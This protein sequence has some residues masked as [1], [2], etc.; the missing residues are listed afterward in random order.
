[1][2]SLLKAAPEEK[3][4]AFYGVMKDSG[5]EKQDGGMIGDHLPGYLTFWSVIVIAGIVGSK[6][7]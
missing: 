4:S 6:L 1:M 5:R 2:S 3:R 7:M